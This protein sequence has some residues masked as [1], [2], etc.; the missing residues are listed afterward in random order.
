[1]TFSA[2][3]SAY[4]AGCK[5]KNA[6]PKHALNVGPGSLTPY[7]VPATLAVYPLIKWYIACSG[8]NLATGGK[9]PNASQVKKNI[10]F[11]WPPTAGIL[12]LSINSRGYDTLVFSVIE[13]SS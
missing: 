10:F 2:N 8:V 6:Y 11:G 9:T 4:T 5:G 13:I 1:M 7:S 12:T 3:N